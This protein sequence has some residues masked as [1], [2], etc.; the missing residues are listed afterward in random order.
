MSDFASDDEDFSG[1][2]LVPQSRRRASLRDV[3]VETFR[4]PRLLSASAVAMALVAGVLW[5]ESAVDGAV[6][7]D[8]AAALPKAEW[9]DITRPIQL[10][11]LAAPDVAK[12]AKTYEARRHSLGGGRRDRLMF[13]T[14]DAGPPLV[15]MEIYRLGTE[16]AAPP[17]FFVAMAREAAM[18]GLSVAR[19]GQP[20]PLPTRFGAFE[21][22]E[23]TLAGAGGEMQC[24]GYTLD[25]QGSPLRIAGIACGAAGAGFDR[26]RLACLLERIDLV[27]AGDDLELQTTFVEAEKRRSL[28]CPGSEG[29]RG[30]DKT[31]WLDPNVTA[32]PPRGAG[33]SPKPKKPSGA[34]T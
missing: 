6:A 15:A 27:S 24:L 23:L 10:F 11:T 8:R 7:T 25:A 33:T 21:A 26:V 28:G 1:D 3:V 4:L 30:R 32:P 31:S 34:G 17:G 18:A 22:A 2:G 19:S 16:G 29:L 12:L 9:I 13:G 14:P 5:L 20:S